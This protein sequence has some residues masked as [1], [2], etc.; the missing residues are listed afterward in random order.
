MVASTKVP[1][2]PNLTPEM[3]RF[4][5]DLQRNQTFR[6]LVADSITA[7]TADIDA[8]TLETINGK[9]PFLQGGGA[10]DGGIDHTFV[11]LGTVSSGTLTIDPLDG[12]FQK[13]INNGA[14]VLSPISG[15]GGSCILHITNAASAGAVTF[16]GWT[17]KYPSSSLDTTN[18]N[19]HAVTMFFYDTDGADYSIQNRQ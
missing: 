4:L 16:T 7:D 15:R 18:A 13:V 10:D 19:K 8:V 9:K 5:D 12:F 1:A 2:D 14:F 6:A 3:R 17:K 11:D